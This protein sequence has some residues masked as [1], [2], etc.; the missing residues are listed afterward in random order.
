MTQPI[1]E[2]PWGRED[3]KQGWQLDRE[4]ENVT[5]G[6]K[7]VSGT[8]VASIGGKDAKEEEDGDEETFLES[9]PFTCVICKASY[10]EPIVTRCGHYFCQP[11][12][13]KGYRKDPTCAA[14]GADTNGVFNSAKGLEKLLEKKSERAAKR[15]LAGT[16]DGDEV[17]DENKGQR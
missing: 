6:K 8:V 3:Y 11:C 10:K 9:I 1:Q 12:A 16:E 2:E 4:W 15:R 14:C 17:S 7:K 13:L 5:Q